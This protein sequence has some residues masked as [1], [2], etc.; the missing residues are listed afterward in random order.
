[1]ISAALQR[2]FESR[3]SG[4]STGQFVFVLKGGTNAADFGFTFYGLSVIGVYGAGDRGTIT[5]SL[6]CKQCGHSGASVTVVNNETGTKYGR[7]ALKR[8]YT[9]LRYAR[10]LSM[11]VDQVSKYVRQ[12]SLFL[13]PRLF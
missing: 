6:G 5:G 12:A 4:L 1:L 9:S 2:I 11:T 8:S 10:R 7:S 13:C 3:F